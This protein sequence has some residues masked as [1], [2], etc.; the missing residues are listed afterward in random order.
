MQ[1]KGELSLKVLG[2]CLIYLLFPKS[3]I[4][5]RRIKIMMGLTDYGEV[6][7]GQFRPIL[8]HVKPIKHPSAWV[9]LI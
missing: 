2:I 4:F 6:D 9:S 3:I 1:K 5:L 8:D 7:A